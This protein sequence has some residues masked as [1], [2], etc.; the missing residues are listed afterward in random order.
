MFQA[1]AFEPR[2]FHEWTRRAETALAL[3][4]RAISTEGLRL[5]AFRFAVLHRR[6]VASGRC[7]ATVTDQL[8]IAMRAIAEEGP[9]APGSTV[10]HQEGRGIWPDAG[11]APGPTRLPRTPASTPVDANRALGFPGGLPGFSAW[12]AAIFRTSFK[13]SRVRLLSNN[14][15]ARVSR[16]PLD[17]CR[18]IER[19][20]ERL[21]C[22]AAP[23][24]HSFAYLLA[25]ARKG[26][27]T[28]SA[29]VRHDRTGY[30]IHSQD[31]FEAVRPSESAHPQAELRAGRMIAVVI[32]D[33]DRENEGELDDGG[34]T[35]HAPEAINFMAKH[36]RGLVCLAMTG[37][38]LG[39]AGSRRDSAAGQRTAALRYC[40]LRSRIDV[41]GHGVTSGISAHDFERK[42]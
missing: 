1:L 28:S 13:V 15:R 38:R 33:E 34:G 10:E 7:A 5:C 3:V 42:T 29:W 40:I 2:N 18:G 21:H 24:P 39:R 6:D 11:Q 31:L 16:L 8:D 36:G 41:K 12:P 17:G 32:D 20:I 22:E 4:L 19:S 37:E 35:G 25:Q 27:G 30:P 26:W 23:T 9:R 14:S